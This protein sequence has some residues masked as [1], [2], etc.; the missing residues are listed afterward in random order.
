MHH[1][2]TNLCDAA[3]KLVWDLFFVCVYILLGD[4]CINRSRSLHGG[5]I[6]CDEEAS[7]EEEDFGGDV[8]AVHPPLNPSQGLDTRDSIQ[9]TTNH[10]GCEMTKNTNKRI[11]STLLQTHHS[12][13]FLHP[14]W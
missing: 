12:S 5:W 3:G 14:Y 1:S 6:Q 8:Y 11:D 7:R 4:K 10:D 2:C 13:E 9:K